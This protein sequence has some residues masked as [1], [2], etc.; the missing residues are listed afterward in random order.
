MVNRTE[1]RTY[2]GVSRTVNILDI[3]LSTPD[4]NT[5]LS[6]VYDRTSGMLLESTTQ[7]ITQAQPQPVRATISY[8]IIETNIFGST[9]TS[10]PSVPEFPIQTIGAT[11]LIVVVIAASALILLK[12]RKRA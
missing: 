1:T 10:S 2:L 12:K 9:P 11:L 3:T 7:T 8:S 6:Y 5:S 4:Y